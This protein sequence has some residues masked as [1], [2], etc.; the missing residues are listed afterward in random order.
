MDTRLSAPGIGV[1]IGQRSRLY[2]PFVTSAPSAFD[3]PSTM[4]L[5]AS[6]LADLATL[7][8]NEIVLDAADAQSLARLVLIDAAELTSQRARY[9]AGRHLLATADDGLVGQ[10]TLQHWLWRRLGECMR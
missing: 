7:A 6:T 10:S 3:A 2:H 8:A 5:Y 1:T 4:T 9:R